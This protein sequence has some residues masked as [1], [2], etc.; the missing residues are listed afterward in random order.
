MIV[1]NIYIRIGFNQPFG[2]QAVQFPIGANRQQL[3]VNFDSQLRSDTFVNNSVSRF[4]SE[5]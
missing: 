4:V 2:F 5:D 3:F 1:K